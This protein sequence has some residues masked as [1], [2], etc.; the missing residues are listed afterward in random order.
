MASRWTALTGLDKHIHLEMEKPS[1]FISY[2]RK[3]FLDDSSD[4]HPYFYYFQI[5]YFIGQD[6]RN[7]TAT[8]TASRWTSV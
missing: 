1:I 3:G 2:S 6:G 8:A 5:D 4:K 7:R